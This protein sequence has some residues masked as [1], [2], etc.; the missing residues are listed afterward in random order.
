MESIL[1]KE[2]IWTNSIGLLGVRGMSSV[3]NHFEHVLC[4]FGGHK[5]TIYDT[6]RNYHLKKRSSNH[7]YT[8]NL[9]IFPMIMLSSLMQFS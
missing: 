8:N 7:E 4:I 6:R 2:N 9:Y 3:N 5:T 1:G